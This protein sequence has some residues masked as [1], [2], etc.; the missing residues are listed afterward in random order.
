MAAA[1]A[2]QGRGARQGRCVIN[3]K[4]GDLLRCEA[5]GHATEIDLHLT[6]MLAQESQCEQAEDG[7]EDGCEHD[8]PFSIRSGP[9][10]AVDGVTPRGGALRGGC[11]LSPG[12]DFPF[13]ECALK[14]TA[15]SR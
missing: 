12:A 7:H 5:E 1:L 3:S 13:H 2:S 15:H 11:P 4:W 10:V 14:A 9:F 8:L 6:S